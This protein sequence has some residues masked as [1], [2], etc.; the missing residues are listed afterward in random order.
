MSYLCNRKIL[1]RL[2]LLV[3]GVCIAGCSGSSSDFPKV[4]W[5]GEVTINQQ[6]IPQDAT[7]WIIVS[8]TS[9]EQA[10]ATRALIENGHYR[11]DAV[12]KGKVNV[13]FS[14]ARQTGRIVNDGVNSVPEEVDL[15][16]PSL[17]SGIDIIAEESN[18][19]QNFD[20]KIRFAM[21]NTS[22]SRTILFGGENLS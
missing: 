7:G 18:Y 14:I 9:G 11:L 16:P 19:K 17:M 8:P 2:F 20:L 15:V 10:P 1:C 5:E 6:P 22:A 3:M 4:Q 13:S 21:R 12:P